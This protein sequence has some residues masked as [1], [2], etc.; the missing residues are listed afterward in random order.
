MKKMFIFSVLATL[1]IVASC[2]KD[3]R[4]VKNLEGKWL[5]V[6]QNGQT[7]PAD[8]TT[9]ITFSNCK[10]KKDEYCNVLVEF[11][12]ATLA[13]N[14]SYNAS[15]K[16]MDDGETLELKVTF[17]GQSSIQRMRIRELDGNKLILEETTDGETYVEEYKKM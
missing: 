11:K 6:K 12:D 1:F 10:L 16:V 7:V 8:E 4:A 15:Y 3:Q 14:E 9:T 17:D 5:L 13:I 2:N